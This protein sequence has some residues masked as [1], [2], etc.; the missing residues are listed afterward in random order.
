MCNKQIEFAPR[1]QIAALSESPLAARHSPVVSG[2]RPLV[3][4]A[5]FPRKLSPRSLIQ[6]SG[7]Q[8]SHVDLPPCATSSSSP[9]ARLNQQQRGESSGPSPCAT[10]AA[11]DH[12]ERQLIGQEQR[13]CHGQWTS[14]MTLGWLELRDQFACLFGQCAPLGAGRGARAG[15]TN[16]R[17]SWRFNKALWLGP[18]GPSASP[19]RRSAN[20]SGKER[21]IIQVAAPPVHWARLAWRKLQWR[22]QLSKSS[23][24]TY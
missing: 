15:M 9:S 16:D 4:A 13:T 21:P 18:G 19:A 20:V 10:A 24:R 3:V 6:T 2:N 7:A 8:V 11:A 5:P 12:N 23:G 14:I 17:N 1:A 22:R